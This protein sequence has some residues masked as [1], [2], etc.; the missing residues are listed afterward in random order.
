MLRPEG[1]GNSNQVVGA[2]EPQMTPLRFKSHREDEDFLP[3]YDVEVII[4][5]DHT[6]N[7]HCSHLF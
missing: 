2:P 3:H 1:Q 6:A 7:G 5:R 4:G